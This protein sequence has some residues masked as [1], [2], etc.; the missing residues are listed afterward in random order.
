MTL[1]VDEH[2]DGNSLTNPDYWQAR[3]PE[4]KNSSIYDFYPAWHD[5]VADYLPQKEGISCLEIGAVPGRSLMFLAARYG[6][7]CTAVDFL[8]TVCNIE[9]AF[10]ARGLPVRVIEADFMTWE[11]E[12]KFDFVYSCG[13]VEHFE[14]YQI[15]IDK[16]WQ[17]VR[18][19]GMMMLTVPTL[20]PVQYLV[21]LMV[22]TRSNM[23]EV[24]ASHNLKIMKL[25]KLI[26][27]VKRCPGSEILAASYN[28][29]MTFWFSPADL[30]VRRW[31]WRLFRYVLRPMEKLVRKTG[32]SSR[33][34]SPEAIVLARKVSQEDKIALS[35]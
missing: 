13:F 4:V 31:T 20:T 11:S 7:S 14:D 22:Y 27:A 8:P 5:V 32:I 10:H 34:F 24:L 15:V 1:N 6:Y 19:G 29:G 2:N 18:D 12:E 9:V 25:R 23:K 30:G 17:F 26:K 28:Q 16:H 33:W 3:R 21:R 35:H